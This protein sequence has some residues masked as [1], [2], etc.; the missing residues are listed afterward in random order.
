MGKSA[1]VVDR[2]AP[3]NKSGLDLLPER[4]ARPFRSS[5]FVSTHLQSPSPCRV[6]KHFLWHFPII[7][8]KIDFTDPVPP[9]KPFG[10]STVNKAPKAGAS[11][12]RVRRFK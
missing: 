3:A 8:R 2:E 4:S 5:H 7:R 9:P 10:G 1:S 6:N 12:Y 11:W